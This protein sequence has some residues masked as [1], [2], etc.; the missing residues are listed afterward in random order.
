MS[1]TPAAQSIDFKNGLLNAWPP[2][3][4]AAHQSYQNNSPYPHIVIDSFLPDT[5][6]KQ[7]M[8]AFPAIGDTGWTHYLHLNEKKH[9]LTKMDL[10]PEPIRV[11]VQQLNAPDFVSWL[12]QL[13]GIHGLISDN[14]LEGGGLHQMERDGFLN[15]HADFTVHPHKRHWRRRVNLLIYLNEDWEEAY[16]GHLELWSRDMKRCEHRISPIFNRCVIF[17]T[18]EDSFHGVPDPITCPKEMTRKSIALYYYTEEKSRPL[19]RATNYQA[20]PGDGLKSIGIYLDKKAIVLYNALKGRLGLSDDFA[21]KVLQFFNR[22][23]RK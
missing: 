4:K 21:S 15:I 17:N 19:K 20:R 23:R 8:D 18:D 6:A 1:N 9:G 22:K 10:L 5:I 7:V 2:P 3:I 13:T 11:L 14:G 16:Q 12:S